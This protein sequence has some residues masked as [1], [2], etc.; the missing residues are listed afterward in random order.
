MLLFKLNLFLLFKL[1]AAFFCGVR[2]KAINENSC[3]SSVKYKWINQNPFNSLYFAV[4]AM[5]A[6][7]TTGV[8]VMYYIKKHRVNMSM[9]VTANQSLFTKK[10]V[11]RINF[12]CNQGK[13]IEKVILN[14]I[15]TKEAQQIELISIGINTVNEQVAEMK[16]QWS[17]KVRS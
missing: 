14:A 10:A 12:T 4:L 16:F 5:A 2:V 8:L 3:I 17:I 11:G 7:L 6:E 15:E 9:L 1:P 13:E